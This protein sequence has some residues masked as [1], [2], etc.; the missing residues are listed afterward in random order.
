[1][2][3]TKKL[4]IAVLCLC[5]VSCGKIDAGSPSAE[6]E[7]DN[8]SSMSASEENKDDEATQ[9]AVQEVRSVT[10]SVNLAGD[11]LSSQIADADSFYSFVG[12]ARKNSESVTSATD[13]HIITVGFKTDDEEYALS[14]CGED[15]FAWNQLG[16]DAEYFKPDSD[17]ASQLLDMMLAYSALGYVDED[18]Q[19]TVSPEHIET[20]YIDQI[21]ESLPFSYCE[22]RFY[23]IDDRTSQYFVIEQDGCAVYYQEGKFTE[24]DVKIDDSPYY[25]ES[26]FYEYF[27]DGEKAYY[28]PESYDVFYYADEFKGAIEPIPFAKGVAEKEQYLYSFAVKNGDNE[29]TVEVW[30]GDGKTDYFLIEDGGIKAMWEYLD[31]EGMTLMN[32]FRTDDVENGDVAEIIAHAEDHMDGREEET[33]ENKLGSIPEDYERFDTDD[34]KIGQEVEPTGIVEEWR[35]YISSGE[36]PF[37]LEFEMSCA[38]RD[39]YQITTYENGNYYYR[40]EMNIHNETNNLGGEEWLIDGR[41][42][43]STYYLSDYESREI[44]EW[45]ADEYTRVPIDLLFENERRDEDYSGKCERAYEVTIGNDKYICEEWSLYLDRLWKV[46]IKDGSIVAWEGDFYDESTVNTVVRLER[47]ADASLLKTPKGAVKPNTND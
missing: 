44:L 39:E 27:S 30:L 23:Y 37:T 32:G 11:K 20:S 7:A 16:T 24:T 22:T 18:A 45:P 34:I 10:L 13:P 28:R 15:V 17:I 21:A 5:L 26:D 19:F 8:I 1:M 47:T 12:S 6:Q 41:L 31:G 42:F 40:H 14:Y 2:T 38:S 9:S 33:E 29:L 35:S 3:I 25:Q 36:A 43:Q 4:S 46:Y